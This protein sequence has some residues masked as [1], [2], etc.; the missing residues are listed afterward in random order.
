MAQEL[1]PEKQRARYEFKKALEE[2]QKIKGRGTEMVS[3][4]IPPGKLISDVSGYLRNE[5]SQSSNIKST[6][7]RKN[8]TGAIESILS[9]LK[10]FKAPPENGMVIFTGAKAVGNDQTR[11][12]QLVVI[13]PQP[14]PSFMY[15]CDSEFFLEPLLSM[16]SHTETYGLLLVDRGECTIG[17]LRGER[18][19]LVKNFESN[20]PRKHT[21]GGQSQRRLERLIEEAAD[22]FFKKCGEQASTIFLAEKELKGVLVG[23]PGATKNY[24]VDGG[25]FHHEIQKKIMETFDTGYTDEHGLRELVEAAHETLKQVGLTREKD[26]LGRFMREIVREHGLAAYGEAEIRRMIEIG[27]VDV[28]I[29]SERLRKHRVRVECGNC[30]DKTE[31][32][33][34]DVDTFEN[35]LGPC[36]KCGT[37]QRTIGGQVDIV[38]EMSDLASTR[39]TRVEIIAGDTSEGETFTNAFGGMGAILRFHVGRGQ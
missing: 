25:F 21:M 32:T 35:S 10:Q 20:V 7:T 37:S 12:V 29:L 34:G 16:L 38:E 23:G 15:R 31:H 18:I 19:E 11:M 17:F 13:P 36:E 5:Y 26:L 30:G 4:Y 6:R 33:V 22:N 3:V 1:D 14:L 9:R 8:V 24:V 27:A 2:L 28:L 39:G